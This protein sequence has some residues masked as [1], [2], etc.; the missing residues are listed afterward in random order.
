MSALD[1]SKNGDGYNNGKGLEKERHTQQKHEGSGAQ[2]ALRCRRVVPTVALDDA[3]LVQVRVAQCDL[4]SQVLVAAG[5]HAPQPVRRHCVCRNI[6]SQSVARGERAITRGLA[7]MLP[8][9]FLSLCLLPVLG[10]L[11]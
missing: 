9:R 6:R 3:F 7:P 5:K 10:E 8:A 4:R 11:M 1:Y 2:Y